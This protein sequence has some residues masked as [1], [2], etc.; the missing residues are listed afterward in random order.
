MQRNQHYE[1]FQAVANLV[2][3]RLSSTYQ[4]NIAN[5]DVRDARPE[6]SGRAFA[7]SVLEDAVEHGEDDVLLGLGEAPQTLELPLQL[8]GRPA[9]P[10][11]LDLLR[12]KADATGYRVIEF[13]SSSSENIASPV[14]RSNEGFVGGGRTGGGAPEWVVKNGPIP[15]GASVRPV[16]PDIGP[17][18]TAPEP[19]IDIFPL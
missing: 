13:P 17:V 1:P 16:P 2:A 18:E 12:I 9:F 4:L 14:F 5:R 11:A 8:G 7:L 15:E 3:R 10:R 19:I 6:G